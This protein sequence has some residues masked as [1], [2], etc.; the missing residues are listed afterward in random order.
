MNLTQIQYFY[1]YKWRLSLGIVF[2][3]ISNYFA[4]D[5]F[6]YARKAVDFIKNNI[7]NSDKNYLQNQLFFLRIAHL[8]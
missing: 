3:G 7:D 8:I 1:K 4:I 2:V 6:T 5:G